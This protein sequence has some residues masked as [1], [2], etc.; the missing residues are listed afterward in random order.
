MGT[1][2]GRKRQVTGTHL[3]CLNVPIA[4]ER[5][6]ALPIDS[7]V[8]CVKNRSGDNQPAPNF[9]NPDSRA[10]E[11]PSPRDDL[12]DALGSAD[13]CVVSNGSSGALGVASVRAGPVFSKQIGRLFAIATRTVA[14]SH[15]GFG[16]D[17]F[18]HGLLTRRFADT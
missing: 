11:E 12:D 6:V 1:T 14:P 9:P 5:R 10:R 3:V 18:W 7:R 17:V 2:D 8:C 13:A 16:I 4:V 15:A